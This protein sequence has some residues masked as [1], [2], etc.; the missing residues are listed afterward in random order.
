MTVN[1]DFRQKI[2]TIGIRVLQDTFYLAQEHVMIYICCQVSKSKDRNKS[3]DT[4]IQSA[5]G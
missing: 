1:R 5:T 4:L 3:H 2:Y